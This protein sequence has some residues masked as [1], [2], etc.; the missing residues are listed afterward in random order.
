MHR[1]SDY[2]G[3]P[4][5]VLASRTARPE[6]AAGPLPRGYIDT[7]DLMPSGGPTR[8]D[9]ASEGYM[10]TLRRAAQGAR[11]LPRQEFLAP[12]PP[13]PMKTVYVTLNRPDGL[14]QKP[15]R[16]LVRDIELSWSPDWVVQR[17]TTDIDAEH[18]AVMWVV[19]VPVDAVVTVQKMLVEAM[20]ILGPL[21]HIVWSEA[22]PRTLRVVE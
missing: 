7:G 12:A 13:T 18:P 11:P 19:L 20:S 4:P 17:L 2:V 21:A 8:L 9:V 16:K 10:E 15:W 14:H 1:L 6:P 3:R 22:T 5:A